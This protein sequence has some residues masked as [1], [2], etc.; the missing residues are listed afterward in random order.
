MV[1]IIIPAT[2]AVA[3]MAASANAF[4]GISPPA[5]R[6]PYFLNVV[7]KEA[8]PAPSAPKKAPTPPKIEPSMNNLAA[9]QATPEAAAETAQ[10][11]VAKKAAPK[12]SAGGAQHKDGVF[13][14]VVRL[15]KGVAGEET[16]NQL[17]GKVIGLHSKA[18]ANFV[19]TYDTP[20]GQAALKFLFQLA[21]VDKSGAI[22]EEELAAGLRKLGFE[23]SEKQIQGIFS[24][25]DTN[26]DGSICWEE[27]KAEAPKTLKTNLTK[28][29]KRNGNDMG[30]LA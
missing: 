26:K 11:A 14:P 2:I 3:T 1:R 29:A 5:N 13:A 20:T 24:R 19:E 12:K 30:L 22:D 9:M 21:D 17:R 27:F 23:L 6:V 8:A 15:A 28:L 4:A 10:P 7:E 18:I 25:A 16:I